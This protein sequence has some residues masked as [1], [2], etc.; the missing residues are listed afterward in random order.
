M[1]DE[2]EAVTAVVEAIEAADT[3]L[4]AE[5]GRSAALRP[6]DSRP[7][8]GIKRIRNWATLGPVPMDWQADH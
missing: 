7:P 5:V 2:V 4:V 1:A 3:E 6:Q 8:V